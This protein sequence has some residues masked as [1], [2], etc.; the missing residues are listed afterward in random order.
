MTDRIIIADDHPIFR[1]GLRRIVLRAVPGAAI[2]EVGTAAE[3][4]RAAAEAAP[5]VLLLLDLV[6]P[7]F[8]GPT[9]IRALRSAYPATSLVVVSMSDDAET[10]GAVMDAGADGF[11]SKAISSSEIVSAITAV[12]AGD[13]VVRTE[14]TISESGPM[15]SDRLS[16]LSVRQREVLRSIA[17]GRSNKEIARELGISPFTVRIHVSAVLRALEVPTRAAAAG[18]AAEL[19]ML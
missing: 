2:V 5:P 17:A 7:G 13:I 19:G 18:I 1:D 15:P 16:R 8:E 12:L 9:S 10:V 11:I 4:D 6:F 14:S 3:L